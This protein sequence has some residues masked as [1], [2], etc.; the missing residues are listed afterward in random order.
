MI[1]RRQLASYLQNRMKI[2]ILNNRLGHSRCG[3]K[4]N[5]YPLV[6]KLRL[7]LSC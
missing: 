4:V 1:I 5:D 3:F 2:I 7:F 6:P